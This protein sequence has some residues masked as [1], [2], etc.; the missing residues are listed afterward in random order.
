MAL[1]EEGTSVDRVA[2]LLD[3]RSPAVRI[4]AA[5]ALCDWG[6]EE[7]G[8]PVLV[9]GLAHSSD[10]VRLYA[11]NALGEIGEKARPALPQLRA[12]MKDKYPPIRNVTKYTLQRLGEGE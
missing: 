1:F 5:Q 7:A 10:T 11:A 6:Q 8:L 3:D 9:Q 4:A 12:A 2:V